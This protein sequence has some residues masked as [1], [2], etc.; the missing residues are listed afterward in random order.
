MKEYDKETLEKVQQLELEILKDFVDICQQNDIPYFGIA[1]T[2]IGALRHQGFIPWDDDIDIGLLR[3]DY[4]RLLNIVERELSNKY[5]IMN[6]DHNNNYPLMTSRIMLKGTKFREESLK[7]IDCPLGIFLD[8]Y[9]FDNVSDDEKEFRKQARD[10]FFWSKLLILRSI[11]F[12][13][14][15]FGGVKAKMVHIICAVVHFFLVLF[16]VPKRKIYEKCYEASTRFNNCKTTKRIDFLCDTNAHMNLVEREK[17]FPLRKRS[18]EGMEL[19]FPNDLDG[20]LRSMYGDYMKL[21]PKEKRK[22][23][24]PFELDFGEWK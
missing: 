5:Q 23:H 22:N 16:R 19:F 24:F 13:V 6:F 21:P 4:E 17:V 15:A 2:G 18:F 10:A 14:L 8:I 1:G 20:Y 9:A 11:P 3:E 12:P 7:K